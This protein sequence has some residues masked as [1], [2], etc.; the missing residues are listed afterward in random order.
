MASRWKAWAAAVRPDP[1]R[2]QRNENQERAAAGSA[3][4]SS[5]HGHRAHALSRDPTPDVW[6]CPAIVCASKLGCSLAWPAGSSSSRCPTPSNGRDRPARILSE[7]FPEVVPGRQFAS[8]S[9]AGNRRAQPR[10]EPASAAADRAG[11]RLHRRG[12]DCRRTSSSCR[13][14]CVVVWIGP[15]RSCSAYGLGT[16]V[17][18]VLTLMAG[19]M[20]WLDPWLVRIAPGRPGGSRCSWC[21]AWRALPSGQHDGRRP[22]PVRRASVPW[23]WA[24]RSPLVVVMIAGLDAARDGLRRRWNTT[25]RARRNISRPAGSRSCLTT[26]TRTC[27]LTWRCSICWAWRSRRLVVGG[28]AGQLLVALFVPAAAV[29]IHAAAAAVVDERAGSRPSCTSRRRGSTASA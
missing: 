7:T 6:A 27:R 12:G 15:C 8:R 10:R 1:G 3:R 13:S 20:G 14:A 11:R 23:L 22:G 16:A 21:P 28:L 5:R 2:G 19:R 4:R 17:L 18:G 26:S 9:W 29:L 25:S 24:R